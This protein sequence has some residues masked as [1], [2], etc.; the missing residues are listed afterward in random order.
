MATERKISPET[1][2]MTGL[3]VA[4]AVNFVQGGIGYKG[5]DDILT[6]RH[7]LEGLIA[8]VVF[9]VAYLAGF[10]TEWANWKSRRAVA[11]VFWLTLGLGVT[12]VAVAITSTWL[13]FKNPAAVAAGLLATDPAAVDLALGLVEGRYLAGLFW[14]MTVES[15]LNDAIGIS[16]YGWASGQTIQ[17][18]LFIVW[19]SMLTGLA[20]AVS[21]LAALFGWRRMRG[22][23]I[24]EGNMLVAMSGMFVIYGLLHHLG[25]ILLTGIGGFVLNGMKKWLPANNL[26]RQ[27]ALDHY[28]EKVNHYG[29]TAIIA[30]VVLMAPLKTIFSSGRVVVGGIALIIAVGI[31]R[32]MA[33]FGYKA[34]LRALNG[35][36]YIIAVDEAMVNTICGTTRLGVT[37]I[38]ALLVAHDGDTYAA[39]CM[40]A[41]VIYSWVFVPMG[42]AIIKSVELH[43]ASEDPRPWRL[44][45]RAVTRI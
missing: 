32:L 14:Q 16:A 2:F 3:L 42:V 44:F 33:D 45:A 8:V 5:V 30:V 27:H 41:A 31:S 15:I 38:V 9:Y 40:F 1:L 13:G 17:E 35:R 29:L 12:G 34:F 25:L 28:W 24:G 11:L 18:A 7:G 10:G 22:S 23:A 26:G 39:D 19:S 37:T 20:M 4:A 6:W 43:A 21:M 36:G